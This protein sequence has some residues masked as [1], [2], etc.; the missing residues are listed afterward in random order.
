MDIRQL[1]NNRN[2]NK[3]LSLQDQGLSHNLREFGPYKVSTQIQA[4]P[5][6]SGS[7]L[8]HSVELPKDQQPNLEMI[9]RISKEL[10]IDPQNIHN[11]NPGE[12]WMTGNTD[13][14]TPNDDEKRF[15]RI[16]SLFKK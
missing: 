14:A 10:N 13:I 1:L 5:S 3:D 2:I 7:K 12:S 4:M 16:N 6:F 9:N 8:I 15:Q 11:L